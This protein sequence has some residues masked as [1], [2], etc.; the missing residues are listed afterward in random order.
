[1]KM[2]QILMAAALVLVTAGKGRAN[3]VLTGVQHLDVT[4]RY[5]EGI[6]LWDSS[7]ID[8]KT[9]GDIAFYVQAFDS[10]GVSVT[11]GKVASLQAYDNSSVNI[12]GGNV[13][14]LY[15]RGTSSVAIRG[16]IISGLGLF[17]LNANDNSLT[18][19]YG[20]DFQATG[21]LSLD[22]NTVVGL[23]VLRG[24]WHDGA[25]WSIPILEHEPD[26]TIRVS[27]SSATLTWDG[28]DP[29]EWTSAHWNPGPLTP[30]GD[31]AMI[32]DS[33]TVTVSTDLTTTPGPAYSLALADGASGGT[34]S[35]GPV[36]RLAVTDGVTVGA[37]GTLSIDGALIAP[38]VNVTGGSLT[39]SIGSVKTATVEGNVILT[40]GATFAVEAIG[41]GIDRLTSTGAVALDGASLN[42]T[43]ASF[44]GPALGDRMQLI[45][46]N[47]GLDGIFETVDGVLLPGN[48]AFA[49][50]YQPDGATVTVVTPGD[51]QVDGD[52]D[53]GDFTYLAANYGQ[54]GKSWVDGDCDG[55]G[56]VNFTD[57]TFLAA[58][59][60]MDTDSTAGAVE[61]RVNAA[62]EPATLAI[63]AFGG[64][65]VL[66]R[67]RE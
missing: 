55:N 44:P 6:L 11:D 1:M 17:G 13:S 25:S 32:V 52:V 18:I 39:T 4:S 24:K 22:G 58:N 3:I 63:L 7:T 2:R 54:S 64:L 5:L 9:G 8:V 57:F 19:I 48:K 42:I 56:T 50:T 27:L 46:A 34:V 45:A 21:G 14:Y 67:R 38:V 53:F 65:A 12:S 47:G 36:G 15:A 26:A 16:G 30:S 40:D 41:A 28:T 62:P 59:Y 33:G 51:F 20:Y 60:G 61:L 35:I 23:G 29:A 49:A 10:S 31:E 43:L 66:R 37:G